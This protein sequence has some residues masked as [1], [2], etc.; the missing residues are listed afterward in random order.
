MTTGIQNPGQDYILWLVLKT[1][2]ENRGL[3]QHGAVPVLGVTQPVIS[4]WEN[5]RSAITEQTLVKVAK[6]YG[7]TV[8][9]LLLEGLGVKAPP[10][11]TKAPTRKRRATKKSS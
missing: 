11:A 1:C 2:R 5:G 9:D 4:E 8:R 6:A 7:I 10:S 3:K